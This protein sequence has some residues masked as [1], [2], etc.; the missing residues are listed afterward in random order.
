MLVVTPASVHVYRVMTGQPSCSRI[1]RTS[2]GGIAAAPMPAT[3]SVAKLVRATSGWPSTSCH[4]VGTPVAIVIF[5]SRMM[6]SVSAADQGSPASTIVVAFAS[7]SHIR[8][9]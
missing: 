2:S 1:V 7:S 5:S 6:R 9:M 8:V 3:R 4:C